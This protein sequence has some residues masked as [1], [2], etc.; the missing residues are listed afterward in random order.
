LTSPISDFPDFL[1]VDLRHLYYIFSWASL[2]QAT[3]N[4]LIMPRQ[5]MPEV[6]IDD[7]ER[8]DRIIINNFMKELC[9]RDDED[10]R[11][12]NIDPSRPHNVFPTQLIQ[13][14]V[15]GA[16]SLERVILGLRGHRLENR[17]NEPF[18]FL[19]SERNVR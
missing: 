9:R 2:V 7:P 8:D 11:G 3:F 5:V 13:E 18:E 19:D 6:S 16:F 15:L 17:G 14:A 10:N 12:M 1:I 4:I